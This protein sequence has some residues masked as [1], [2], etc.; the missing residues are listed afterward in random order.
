MKNRK[1]FCKGNLDAQSDMVMQVPTS[2]KVIFDNGSK[3]KL[4]LTSFL[5]ETSVTLI[6][7]SIKTH[8]VTPWLSVYTR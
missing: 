7:T 8:R 4:Y 3:F 1:I 2:T 5:I 6:C